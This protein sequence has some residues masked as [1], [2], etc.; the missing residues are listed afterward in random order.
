MKRTEEVG[1]VFPSRSFAVFL[2]EVDRLSN[3]VSRK[4]TTVLVL[5][6]AQAVHHKTGPDKPL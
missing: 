1:G 2:V 4:N 3:P 5:A 6:A